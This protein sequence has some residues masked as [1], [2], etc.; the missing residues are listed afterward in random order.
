VQV[1]EHNLDEPLPDLG[2]FDA[3]VSSFSIHHCRRAEEGPLLRDSQNT[4][5]GWRLP[6]PGARGVCNSRFARSISQCTGYRCG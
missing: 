1:I 6:Q 2:H 3:I 5:T 4:R